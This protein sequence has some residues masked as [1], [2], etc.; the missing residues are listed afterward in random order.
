MAGFPI[1]TPHSANPLA[2]VC[3]DKLQPG[4]EDGETPTE[5]VAEEYKKIIKRKK[6][7]NQNEKT[8]N[9]KKRR[10]LST[11]ERGQP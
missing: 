4:V 9:T 11:R 1:T 2:G 6:Q 5:V 10:A 3:G 8:E 7:E